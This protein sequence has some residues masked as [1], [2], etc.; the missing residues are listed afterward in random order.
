MG[1]I[2]IFEGANGVGKTTYIERLGE[3][4]GVKSFR[5]F[6]EIKDSC[7]ASGTRC[8]GAMDE[9]GVPIN[10]HVEDFFIAD[11]LMGF[12]V[13]VI[14]DRSLPSAIV[15]GTLSGSEDRAM[16]MLRYWEKML[17]KASQNRIL[18]VWLKASYDVAKQRTKGR[19]CPNKTEYN[20]LEY[21]YEKM[22]QQIK[23]P[24]VQINTTAI[25]PSVGIKIICQSLKK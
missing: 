12:D 22:F 16:V 5:A 9:F 21:N 8:Y 15:Y 1:L 20:K 25:K 4:L 2:I 23:L 13:D 19:W 24:K 18:Y 14:L 7:K 10:T 11:F 17:Q 6:K 3:L